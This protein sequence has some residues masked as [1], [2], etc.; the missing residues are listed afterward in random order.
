MKRLFIQKIELGTQS[1]DKENMNYIKNVLRYRSG[2]EIIV[3]DGHSQAIATFT[4]AALNITQITH[5]NVQ[6]PALRLAIAQIKQPRFE[7]LVEK[8]TEIGVSEIFLLTT[9]F[10]QNHVRNLE[11]V[12]KIA[13]EA[14]RQCERITIPKIHEAITL[15]EFI[16]Q[17]SSENWVFGHIEKD[18]EKT[19]DMDM[20]KKRGTQ[21]NARCHGHIIKSVQ[22]FGLLIGP[23]GGFEENE[24][25]KLI[26]HY[27]PIC[28]SPN[29]LRAETSALVGLIYI[30]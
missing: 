28:L 18:L 1:L 11:R 19:D 22:A 8:A 27:Q 4:Q 24:S 29:I 21:Q 10:T 9:K 14:A 26:D 12:R 30:S 2:E 7:W 16:A 6:E 23:E 20:A 3:F 17:H 13:I 5:E 15:N 25:K